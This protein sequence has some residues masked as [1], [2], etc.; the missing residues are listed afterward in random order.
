MTDNIHSDY[1]NSNLKTI[2]MDNN[3]LLPYNLLYDKTLR[4]CLD[5]I[6]NS[7]NLELANG[8]AKIGW[9][10]VFHMFN[11]AD[12]EDISR[13]KKSLQT[14]ENKTSLKDKVFKCFGVYIKTSTNEQTFILIHLNSDLKWQISN[15]I[16][17][18][19]A[20]IYCQELNAKHYCINKKNKFSNH[21]SKEQNDEL[22]Q[23]LI[24]IEVDYVFEL[25]II[26]NKKEVKKEEKKV[27]EK[28]KKDTSLKYNE[29]MPKDDDKENVNSGNSKSITRSNTKD[30]K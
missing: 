26:E 8:G 4:E 21:L 18:I 16:S 12:K 9:I 13:L 6:T 25:A 27:V 19:T 1:F 11:L 29:N 22:K 30:K 24:K 17:D 5:W 28:N 7:F 3:N 23:R 14:L 2:C 20:S 15:H 10:D